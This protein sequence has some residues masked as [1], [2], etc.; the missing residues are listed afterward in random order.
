MSRN[1]ATVIHLALLFV[2]MGHELAEWLRSHNVPDW[3]GV[4]MLCAG[5]SI[6]VVTLVLAMT[7]KGDPTPR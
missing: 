1:R 5:L 3:P 6:A 2:I 7:D 4:T